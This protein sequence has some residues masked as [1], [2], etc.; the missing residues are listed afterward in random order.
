[1]MQFNRGVSVE[2]L[3]AI[4]RLLGEP[5]EELSTEQAA[6]R[7]IEAVVQLRREIGIPLSIRD[8]GG[9]EAQLPG[10]AAKS[11]A[12]KRLMAMNPRPVSEADLLGILREA[13]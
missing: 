6:D 7:A 5:V 10:F 9:N 1:M 3:A 13:F 11:F 12:I 8:L 4:A 2:R